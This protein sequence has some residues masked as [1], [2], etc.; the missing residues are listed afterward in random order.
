MMTAI[1][2]VYQSSSNLS[3]TG[4]SF[5]PFLTKNVSKGI[6]EFIDKYKL[7]DIGKTKIREGTVVLK[8][9][10]V[11]NEI[12]AGGYG[13]VYQCINE[14]E[15]IIKVEAVMRNPEQFFHEV[16]IQR[17]IA[18]IGVTCNIDAYEVNS[19]PRHVYGNEVIGDAWFY[20]MVMP[21]LSYSLKDK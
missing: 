19:Y 10:E 16:T 8:T 6:L 18:K 14:P 9:Y 11:G 12:N 20:T 17:E 1:K 13:S 4:A 3:A 7:S 15:K 2:D 21:K 5:D